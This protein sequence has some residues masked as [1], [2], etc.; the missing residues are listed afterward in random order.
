MIMKSNIENYIQTWENRCYPNEI[1]D[2]V[3]NEI[4]D[5]VPSYKRVALAILRNDLGDLGIGGRKSEFYSILK[6]IELKKRGVML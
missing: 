6:R 1:P 5:M 3:P 2:E 4:S